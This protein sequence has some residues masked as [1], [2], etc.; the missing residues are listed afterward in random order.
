MTETVPAAVVDVRASAPTPDE[1]GFRAW[2]TVRMPA[3]RR[4]AY[5]LTGDW[6]T[7]DD[8]VQD[9]LVSLYARWPRLVSRGSPDA[10]A[11]KVLVSRFLDERRRPWRRESPSEIVPDRVDPVAA[12]DLA[13]IDDGDAELAAALAT[14]PADQRAVVVLRYADDLALDEVARVLDLPLGTVKSRASR[15][16]QALRYEL[17]R[18]GHPLAPFDPARVDR[19]RDDREAD[20]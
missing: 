3:L 18:R 13:R 17:I 11:S 14:L 9:A 4:K 10:Y 6:H 16:T 19:A 12:R 20:S 15:G 5:L 1:A 2:A 7:A 8:V